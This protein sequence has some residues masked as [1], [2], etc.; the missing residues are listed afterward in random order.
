MVQAS[1]KSDRGGGVRDVAMAL[2]AVVLAGGFAAEAAAATYHGAPVKVGDGYARVIVETDASDKPSEIAVLL[3]HGALNGLPAT[4]NPDNKEG[5]WSYLL[6]MPEHESHTG[7][8]TVLIDWMAQGHPPPHIY[9]V[10][11]F[12][13]HFYAAEA[14]DLERV[15]FR[16]PDDPAAKVTDP[17][18][19]PEGYQVIAETAVDKMGVHA[20]D[21]GAPEFHGKPFTATFVYGYYDGKLVFLEPMVARDFLL[22]EPD[23][24]ASVKKPAHV[25]LSGYYPTGYRVRYDPAAQAWRIALT[26]LEHRADVADRATT[27]IP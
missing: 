18:L 10:P 19:L 11:H 6:P 26:G 16:G 3:S 27:P 4:P 25:S 8:R 23:F 2:A 9:T 5:A 21:T 1:M 13:V 22:N 17:S 14:Q 20:I 7:F 12:D 24:A 15:A